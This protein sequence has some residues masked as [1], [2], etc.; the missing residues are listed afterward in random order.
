MGISHVK[1]QRLSTSAHAHIPPRVLLSVERD[2]A[3]KETST[4]TLFKEK[5][6]S[7]SQLP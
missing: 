7:G 4:A 1:G 6:F 3:G 5:D 2:V